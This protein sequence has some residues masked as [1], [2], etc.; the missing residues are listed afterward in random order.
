MAYHVIV[1]LE[2][3]CE[4]KS[5]TKVFSPA[6]NAYTPSANTNV[7]EID[8]GFP[9]IL[10]TLNMECVK[11]AIMAARILNCEIPKKM[12]FDRKNY[13]YPDLP[14]G[15]QIT[16]NTMPVGVHG[17]IDVECNGS[18]INV[19]IQDIH[20]EED[21]A[22]LD[23]LDTMSLIDYNRAGVP[24]LE[25]VTDPCITSADAAVAFLDTMCKIYQYTDISD[26]TLLK[27]TKLYTI[28][29]SYIGKSTLKL[30]TMEIILHQKLK[31]KILIPL[32]MSKMP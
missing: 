20:L 4:M 26:I 21:S 18:I 24:L 19:S 15:Y 27:G 28:F 23:H 9:G 3:H 32:L 17:N 7:N 6:T 10:P 8:L 31:L 16:Q 14:K 5:K 11:K 12:M 2:M 13:Y 30:K 22:A 1:G 29:D 25:C